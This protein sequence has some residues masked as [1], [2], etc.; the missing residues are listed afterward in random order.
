MF[1]NSYQNSYV[2]WKRIKNLVCALVYLLCLCESLWRH[3]QARL[4]ECKKVIFP[5]RWDQQKTAMQQLLL[6]WGWAEDF[7]ERTPGTSSTDP[8]EVL[9]FSLHLSHQ[10][11]LKPNNGNRHY[12]FTQNNLKNCSLLPKGTGVLRDVR[13]CQELSTKQRAQQSVQR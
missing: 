2:S 1:P 13:P 7:S 3:K 5:C 12:V 11:E 10:Y 9:P 6:P 4:W 8:D